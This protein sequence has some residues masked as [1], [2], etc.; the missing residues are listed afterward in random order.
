MTTPTNIPKAATC[1]RNR[2]ACFV[3]LP[4]A[5]ERVARG[6]V[7]SRRGAELPN[8]IQLNPL[9]PRW[10]SERL[11]HHPAAT[12]IVPALLRAPTPHV[13]VI[14]H[15]EIARVLLAWNSTGRNLP[16]NQRTRRT[17]VTQSPCCVRKPNWRTDSRFAQ[18]LFSSFLTFNHSQSQGIDR[19]RAWQI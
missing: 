5:D 18:P 15:A 1:S 2:A 9:E 6:R 12:I 8:L 16:D 10:D 3:F 4:A 17:R 14:G 13:A 11:S 19:R 7:E